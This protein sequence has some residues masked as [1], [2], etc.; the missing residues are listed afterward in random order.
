MSLL[1]NSEIHKCLIRD[2]KIYAYY[3]A[4]R[5]GFEYQTR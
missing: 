3:L 1:K 4:S 2:G 5:D